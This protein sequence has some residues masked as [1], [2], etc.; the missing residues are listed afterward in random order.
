[1]MMV[2]KQ[3]LSAFLAVFSVLVTDLFGNS[4]HAFA[5]TASQNLF[6]SSRTGHQGR[7]EQVVKFM[8]LVP[9]ADDEGNGSKPGAYS[10][11]AGGLSGLTFSRRSLLSFVSGTAVAVVAA[12]TALVEPVQ[13][14]DEL[15]DYLYTILRVKEATQQE[16]RLI[17]N[18]KFKDVQRANVKL[19]VRFMIKNYNLADTM[20]LAS[21]FLEQSSKRTAA[22]EAGDRAVENLYTILEYFDSSDVQNLKV[23]H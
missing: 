7:Q 11:T 3:R 10:S 20:N 2:G 12:G 5:P 14:A 6:L 18:G 13:A 9:S 23:S 19:A 4:C 17:K 8:S 21:G 16:I 22:G 1:M 15:E